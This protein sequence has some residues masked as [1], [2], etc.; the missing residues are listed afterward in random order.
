M[1]N[2]ASV[3]PWLGRLIFWGCGNIWIGRVAAE[4]G[5]H[6][7]HAIQVSLALSD[8]AVQLMTPGAAW[9]AYRAAIVAANQSHAFEA[10]ANLVALIFIEPESVAGR[11]LRQRYC[12]GIAA[13]D[14]KL[15]GAAATQLAALYAQG[16]ADQDI[17]ACARSVV[18]QLSATAAAPRKALD[19]RVEQAIGLLRQRLD[20]AVAM[21]DIAQAV[22]LS[23][24]RFRHLFVQET[25]VR[26][27]PYVLWLRLEAAAAAY[28]AGSSLTAASHAAGFADSA[29]LSRTF[30][31]MFGVPAIDVQHAERRMAP[32]VN[33]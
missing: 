26:F 32:P 24:E 4:T 27:R 20:D 33:T 2:G 31:R 25:G 6:A 17:A 23:P 11:A 1:D 18:A 14:G 29:H 3:K 19:K 30:K 9:T 28:A 13:L 8:G 22:H 12:E 16:A 7:H 5:F 21:A 10:P 15:L